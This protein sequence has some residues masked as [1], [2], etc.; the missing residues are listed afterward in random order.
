MYKMNVFQWYRHRRRRAAVA[1]GLYGAVVV[2]SRLPVF[3]E[4]LG[5]ADTIDGRFDL[6]TLHMFLITERLGAFGAEGHALAQALFDRMFRMMELNLRESGVGDLGIPKHIKKMMKAF[7]G[8][9]HAY[10]EAV[11]VHGPDALRQALVRNV[12]RM[13]NVASEGAAVDGTSQ[14]GVPAGAFVMAD[15]MFAV[16][17]QFAGMTLEQLVSGPL[18]FPPVMAGH[19]E[20]ACA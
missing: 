3:Y 2:Q 5:V 1:T 16:R 20:T 9:F 6:L 18:C 11:S 19:R 4:T 14:G 10:G 12:Y 7:N 15:Y 13:A 8:R 17:H